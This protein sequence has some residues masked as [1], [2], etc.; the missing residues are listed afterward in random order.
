[1]TSLRPVWGDEVDYSRGPGVLWGLVWL[2]C[3]TLDMV[4]IK[5]IVD[6]FPCNGSE[7]TLYQN[8]LSLP[9]LSVIILFSPLE[10]SYTSFLVKAGSE[11]AQIAL[12]FSCIAGALLSFTGMTLR[13]ELSATAFT[14]LGIICKM[15]SSLLNE[16]FVESEKN[17]YSLVFIFFSILSSALYRQ[18]PSRLQNPP[19][20]QTAA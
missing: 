10:S 4:Y 12:F 3:F 14:I 20:F 18:A 2:S 19:G 17:A 8:A 15:A 11:G 5:H 9:F 16:A 6:A 7:R 1:M 13:S